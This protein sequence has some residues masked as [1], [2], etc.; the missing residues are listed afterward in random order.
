MVKMPRVQNKERLQTTAREKHQ[1]I[2]K[3]KTIR[4]T[5]DLSAEILKVR[6][7]WTD[8]FQNLTQNN[9]QPMLLY[10]AKFSL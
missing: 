8:V 10:L 1:V 7:A 6:I 9:C 4:V 3:G 5:A 2:Y